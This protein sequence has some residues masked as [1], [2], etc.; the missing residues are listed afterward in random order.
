MNAVSKDVKDMLAAESSLALTYA[1]DLFIGVEPT[2][3][4]N[5]VTIFDTPSFP[6]DLYMDPTERYYYSSIQIR[7]RNTGYTEGITLA[8]NIM[9]LLHARANETW[10]GT[11]YTVITATGEPA[12][13]DMDANHR[14]RFIVNFNLQRR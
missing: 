11:L 6:P 8:R 13:L 12:W 7:V 10:N 9:E 5:T 14:S 3:P 2:K 1:K 4:D